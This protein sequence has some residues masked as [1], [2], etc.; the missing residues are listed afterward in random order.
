MHADA[1]S[2]RL[3]ASGGRH[4][5][6]AASVSA[7]GL[8]RV[9]TVWPFQSADDAND[10][11]LLLDRRALPPVEIGEN[12]SGA[13]GCM[14]P[15]CPLADGA[16][17]GRDGGDRPDHP[18]ARDASPL[19]AGEDVHGGKL[20]EKRP[21]AG[22]VHGARLVGAVDD[23]DCL[24]PS[25][26]WIC[27]VE[28]GLAEGREDGGLAAVRLRRVFRD[29][30]AL[31]PRDGR[32]HVGAVRLSGAFVPGD[33]GRRTRERRFAPCAE[34]VV[35]CLLGDESVFDR[36]DG[37]KRRGRLREK[38]AADGTVLSG[39]GDM[40]VVRIWSRRRRV[41]RLPEVPDSR[42]AVDLSR[43]RVGVEGLV[44]VQTDR[45]AGGRPFG[46]S[47]ADVVASDCEDGR[48]A[49]CDANRR[50]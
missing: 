28:H 23:A 10:G 36:A 37:G 21:L 26:R 38:I 46:D 40:A 15:L 17:G 6:F 50:S 49:A 19:L 25:A 29:M 48:S 43:H 16:A 41:V 18:A 34:H 12:D 39:G 22:G 8:R 42:D 47:R 2:G 32:G 20:R 3:F 7:C 11:R 35:S 4:Y 5:V 33:D 13:M 30:A 31:L 45:A 44:V 14:R 24:N 9:Q 27:V 1:L